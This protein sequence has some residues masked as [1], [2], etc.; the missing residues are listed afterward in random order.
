MGISIFSKTQQSSFF[1]IF[2]LM[3][4]FMGGNLRAEET[5]VIGQV[6]NR[7]DKTPIASVNVQF[8]NFGKVTQT[9]EE[10]YFMIR[11][12]G[13]Q[14]T[15]VFTAVGF[16]PH[17]VKIKRGKSVGI[18]VE[19]ESEDV[20]L[21]E[22]MVMQNNNSAFELIKKVRQQKKSNDYS[23]LTKLTTLSSE[24][25]LILLSKI[26]QRKINKKIYEQLQQGA[27]KSA[28]SS[29]TIPLYMAQSRYQ[30]VEM[31]KK[32][33]D[34]NTFCSPK[35]SENS[36]SKLLAELNSPLDFYENTISLF[37][38]SFISPLSNM[39]NLYY[40]FYLIDSLNTTTGKQYEIRFITKNGKNLAFNGQVNIDST[41]L[42]ITHIEAELPPKANINYIHNLQIT[43]EF[44]AFPNRSWRREKESMDINMNFELL[45]DSLHPKPEIMLRRSAQFNYTDTVFVQPEKF[46]Q[47]NYSQDTLVLKMDELN[48]T[49]AMRTAKLMADLL[50]A[51]YIPVGKIDVG[52]FSQ[53]TSINDQEGL[54]LTLPIKT[55]ETL[56]KNICLGGSVGYA[57]KNETFKY[58]G[59]A[60]YRLPSDKKRMLG[61]TYTNDYRRVDYNFNALVA[62]EYPLIGDGEELSSAVLAFKLPSKV[63]LL[64]EFTFSFF[65][66]WNKDV[67]STFYL[68]ANELFANPTLAMVKNNQYYSTLQ[69]NSA[70]FTTRF[71]FDEKTSEDHLQRSYIRNYKPLFYATFEIGKYQL[72]AITGNYGK[73]IATLK[74]IKKLDI[75]QLNYTMEAGTLIGTVPY[76]L[77]QIPPGSETFGYGIYHY[78]MM[79]YMEFA[80]DNYFNLHSELIMN[81]LILNQIPL[82]KNFNFREMFSY[83]F[84]YGSL[85]DA[86]R[87][88]L[89]Y[90]IQ[91]QSLTNPYSEVG[92]GLT[93]IF[94]LFSIQSMWRLSHFNKTGVVPWGVRGSLNIRF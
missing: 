60:Q 2:L 38:K 59:L 25:I 29:L 91:L 55:N 57:F 73:I 43:Q 7:E 58:S 8:K 70:T 47:G 40:N 85:R 20:M 41:S 52:Q 12:R 82:I 10:G 9:N 53:F 69:Q 1:R 78:N 33:M 11:N 89:D 44:K 22:I 42:A 74:Q 34:K 65:N 84:A 31:E 77:L 28:D 83:N 86:H 67:E 71:S 56:W 37:G 51:G 94:R 68:R 39:A 13:F 16:K 30:Q 32:L 46:A 79:N 19:L 88:L 61:L 5:V 72:G 48:K 63:S 4:L 45:A 80:T 54:R 21:Q 24:Q 27:L 15:L 90:P 36:I 75:G 81:G 64:N 6:L 17:E 76:P 18:Q 93:N 14:T 26:N 92:V 35:I 49:T 50:I 62:R 3:I 23:K 87:N 66:D